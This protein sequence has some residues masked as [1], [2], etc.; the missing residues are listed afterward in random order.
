MT[1]FSVRLIDLTTRKQFPSPTTMVF[2]LSR[3]LISSLA[4]LIQLDLRCFGFWALSTLLVANVHV[5]PV[6]V[7]NGVAWVARPE[8]S[9]VPS[10]F[11]LDGPS[12]LHP[13]IRLRTS[14]VGTQNV[15]DQESTHGMASKRNE[16]KNRYYDSLSQTALRIH[17]QMAFIPL[18]LILHAD[19]FQ[20]NERQNAWIYRND[21]T[22]YLVFVLFCLFHGRKRQLI[23]DF[24]GK[25]STC[26]PKKGWATNR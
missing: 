7:W 26:H 1:A 23:V 2:F 8:Y 19:L 5:Q 18:S 15:H 20:L 22:F 24:D 10:S 11:C 12:L 17:S 6:S 13:L 25:E 21:V 3:F 4:L 9:L 14:V 16:L